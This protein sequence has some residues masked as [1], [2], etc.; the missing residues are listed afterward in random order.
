MQH[1]GGFEILR[2]ACHGEPFK[3]YP[4]IL[5]LCDNVEN[6][7]KVIETVGSKFKDCPI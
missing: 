6:L 3:D 7:P 1:T 4:S 5:K 2:N